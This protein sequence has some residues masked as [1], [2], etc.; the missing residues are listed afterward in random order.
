VNSF[1]LSFLKKEFTFH[2]SYIHAFDIINSLVFSPAGIFRGVMDSE[3]AHSKIYNSDREQTIDN[4][5]A[6]G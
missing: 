4:N 3:Y 2:S 5:H 1:L 6:V